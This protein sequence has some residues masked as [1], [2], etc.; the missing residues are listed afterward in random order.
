MALKRPIIIPSAHYISTDRITS[1]S[2]IKDLL[3][4]DYTLYFSLH[5]ICRLVTGEVV[6]RQS[7]IL[8]VT[9]IVCG[10]YQ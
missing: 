7:Y 2:S 1:A 5:Y 3:T 10:I 4:F 6:D 9:L 8:N